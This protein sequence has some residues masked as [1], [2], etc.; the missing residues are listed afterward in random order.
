MNKRS[1]SGIKP[2]LSDVV[3]YQ[4]HDSLRFGI[5]TKIFGKNKVTIRTRFMNQMEELDV[6]DLR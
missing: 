6:R 2:Q 1:M 3:T 5:I 4:T